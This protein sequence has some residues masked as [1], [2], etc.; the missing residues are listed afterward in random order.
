MENK[1]D[2]HYG[3]MHF[4]TNNHYYLEIIEMRQIK[5]SKNNFKKRNEKKI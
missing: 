1:P 3:Q 5:N 2:Q 4:S